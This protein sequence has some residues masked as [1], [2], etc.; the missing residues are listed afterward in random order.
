METKWIAVGLVLVL[1]ILFGGTAV[2]A[3]NGA[4]SGSHSLDSMNQMHEQMVKNIQDPALRQAM[5]AMHQRHVQGIENG[6]DSHMA[7]EHGMMGMH[8]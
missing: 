2:L 6:E 1:A 3:H 8:D 5:D 7:G 4:V